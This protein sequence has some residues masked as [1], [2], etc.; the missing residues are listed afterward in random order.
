[1]NKQNGLVIRPFKRAHTNREKARA[2]LTPRWG[3]CGHDHALQALRVAAAPQPSLRPC[4]HPGPPQ[5]YS[6]PRPPAQDKELLYL[7][8]Y[9]CLVGPRPSL[10]DL[11][12]RKWESY[13]SKHA[14]GLAGGS[15]GA[16]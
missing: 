9:L 4:P 8:H 15:G 12:H 11:N 14:G 7:S 6:R 13:L 10:S 2:A 3:R 1:M 16:A 5:L